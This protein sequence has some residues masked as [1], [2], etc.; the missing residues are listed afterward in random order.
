[1]KD[2]NLFLSNCSI[3]ENIYDSILDI[4]SMY[5][6]IIN[7]SI[8]VIGGKTAI[9]IFKERIPQNLNSYIIDF[10]IYGEDSTYQNINHLTSNEL[11]KNSS[12]IFGVGG[13]RAID[14]AKV[15]ADKLSKPFF[16][17]PTLASN[18]AGSTS[19]S[20]IYEN[21]GVFKEYYNLKTCPLHV[22]IN[23]KIIAES[24]Y[25]LFWAGIGDALSKEYEVE[26]ASRNK[27]LNNKALLGVTLSSSISKP[28]FEYGKSALDDCMNNKVS[29][30]LEQ[31][32]FDIIMTTGYVSN[33]TIDNDFYY[34]SSL[35]HAFYYGVTII[36]EASK[37]LHGEIVALGVLYLLAYDKKSKIFYKTLDFYKKLKLP[38]LLEDIDVKYSNLEKIVQKA[39]TV[40]EWSCSPFNISQ[41]KFIKTILEVESFIKDR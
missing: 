6:S 12:I 24:P 20:V 25:Q 19:L 18:C 2:T 32:V 26:F 38:I 4:V 9:S 13:G 35:A 21:S 22:F 30:E 40:L 23:T 5:T 29:Y 1:M 31:V 14:T 8:I 37:H 10:I 33:L 28:L 11:I 34:N 17:F 3:G 15:V 41:E 7:K 27:V 36:P 16:S 39:S